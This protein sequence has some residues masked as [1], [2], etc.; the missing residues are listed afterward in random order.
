MSID[1]STVPAPAVIEVL[2]FETILAAML[3]DLRA[4]A[5][6]FD[7]LVESDPAYKILEVAAYR[8]TLLRARINDAA[9]GVMLAYATG[10]DLDNLAVLF[11]VSR[12]LLAPANPA[13]NPPVRAVW[14][15]DDALRKR[16]LVS[17]DALTTAGSA[18]AYLAHALDVDGISDAGVDSPTPGLVRV[19]VL[20]PP[21]APVPDAAALS[22]VAAALNAEDVRPL[23]D[24]VSVVAAQP[25]D[26]A[27]AATLLTF[28]GPDAGTI[29]TN[30]SAA[31]AAYVAAQFKVGRDITLSG[32]YAALHQP[33]VAR[34]DLAAPTANLAIA[35]T[36]FPRCTG[37]TVTDGGVLA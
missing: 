30:A 24:T 20:G 7:A 16:V 28:P 17:L 32:L 21:A 13:A 5:P 26:F 25:V 29:L 36:Q 8:E 1:L 23:T 15:A 2:S 34:V 14:E 27:V 31:V 33:G 9:K 22:R 4:R 11:G 12:N 18:N 19:V 37:I 10:S 6:E 3:A 35:R